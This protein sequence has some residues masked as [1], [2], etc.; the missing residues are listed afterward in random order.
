MQHDAPYDPQ[1]A[2]FDRIVSGLLYLLTQWSL[3][4]GRPLALAVD[5]HLLM[6]AEHPDS[7]APL[8]ANC[9]RLRRDWLAHALQPPHSERPRGPVH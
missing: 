9:L 2:P 5:Q 7:S 3:R 1:D 4:G 8:R 6:L